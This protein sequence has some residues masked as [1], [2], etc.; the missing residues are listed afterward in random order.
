MADSTLPSDISSSQAILAVA[1]VMTAIRF[2]RDRLGFTHEWVW[3][4][5]PDF[6]GV[7]WGKVNLMF[8][9]APELASKVAGHQHAFMVTGI[10]RLYERHRQNG[11]PIVSP[12]GAK[13]W[14]LR[15]YTA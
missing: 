4:D 7:S 15:E 12:L 5:P 9:L 14:G 3:G 13:P 2:Y 6:G 11:V 1:D 8:N 10:D